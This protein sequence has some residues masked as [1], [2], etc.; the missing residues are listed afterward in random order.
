MFNNDKSHGSALRKG[1]ISIPNQIYSI[2]T[3]TKSRQPF[4][5]DLYAARALIRILNSQETMTDADTMCF[6]VMPDHLHWLMQLK[7]KKTLSVTVQ[8]VKSRTSKSLGQSVWQKGFHDRA[9]RRD[10]DIVA[11]ACYITANPIRA[12]LVKNIREYPHWDATWI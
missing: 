8:S 12:G 10:E 5:E 3:V 2:T 9:I 7:S 1:R 4:F 6:V 11:I